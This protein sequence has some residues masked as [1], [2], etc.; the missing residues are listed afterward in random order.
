MRNASPPPALVAI[1][2][3]FDSNLLP[4]EFLLAKLAE[5]QAMRMKL[6]E[7]KDEEIR[8]VEKTLSLM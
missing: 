2:G 1:K 5:L 7:E 3:S 6:I 4:K 8:A